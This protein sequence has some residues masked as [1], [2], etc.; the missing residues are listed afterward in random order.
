MKIQVLGG[1]CSKCDALEKMAGESIGRLGLDA[2]VEHVSDWAEIA[3]LGVL[4]TPALVVDGEVK[5]A[6]RVPSADEIDRILGD[7]GTSP[8]A[9]CDCGC[10]CC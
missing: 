10:N 2:T 9:G 8:A 6:G 4:T 5:L 7:A 1:G 3:R